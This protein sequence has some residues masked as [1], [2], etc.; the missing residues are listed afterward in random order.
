MGQLSQRSGRKN[1][2]TAAVCKIFR[3]CRM[4]VVHG[5]GWFIRSSHVALIYSPKPRIYFIHYA[6]VGAE[7]MT[8]NDIPNITKCRPST[9]QARPSSL[10]FFV[11]PRSQRSSP[12]SLRPPPSRPL[13][14]RSPST[15]SSAAARRSM[16]ARGRWTAGRM[17]RVVRRC[18][19]AG[20]LGVG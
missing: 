11:P 6:F 9:N 19:A 14:R 3:R 18:A 15:R 5:G 1:P 16:A 7:D 20:R 2:R 13:A 10:C 12:S 17:W 4:G 8:C